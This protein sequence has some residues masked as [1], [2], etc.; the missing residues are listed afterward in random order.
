MRE[1]W[2]DFDLLKAKCDQLDERI[3]KEAQEI[4]GDEYVYIVSAAYRH[5]FAAHKLAADREGNMIFISKE[6]NS[7]GCA[8]TVDVSYPSTP[9][10]LKYCPQLVNAMCR[11]VLRFARMDVWSKYDFAPHDVGRYPIVN[12]QVYGSDRTMDLRK[13]IGHQPP[14]YLMPAEPERYVFRSQ[15]PVE[16][17]G[18]M[19]IMMYAAAFF[20]GDYSLIREYRDLTYMALVPVIQPPIM[21]ALT[22]EEER[23]IRMPQLRPVSKTELVIFPILVTIIVSLILPDAATLV[24]C[25]MLG[26]L[27]H[28]SGVTER[29]NKTV[30]NE[31]CNIVTI[32]LGVTVGATTTGSEFLSVQTILIIIM[33]V[34][35]FGCGTAGGVLMAKLMNKLTGGRVNPLIGSA[36]VSA[37]PMAAR[38]SNKVGQEYDP[39]NFLRQRR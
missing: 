15:M 2:K 17:S 26:N 8:G 21:K 23:R 25:L 10:F 22:T 4:G 36:G 13:R 35:A 31:L 11:P 34:F 19:L 14:Y 39:G 28:V 1:T 5:V 3:C 32:F 24:G 18:N 6:N 37:V 27:L 38:V 7:N 29:L 16:E 20:S 9:M 33:G 30:Q 12:G